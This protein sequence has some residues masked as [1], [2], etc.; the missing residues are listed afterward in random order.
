MFMNKVKLGNDYM[1]ALNGNNYINI[2][3]VKNGQIYTR[4]A[5]I[6]GN[7]SGIGRQYCVYQY[8]IEEDDF[9]DGNVYVSGSISIPENIV[10]DNVGNDNLPQSVTLR[11]QGSFWDN[12]YNVD[13]NKI[14]IDTIAPEIAGY[15]RDGTVYKE[16]ELTQWS[17]VFSEPISKGNVTVRYYDSPNITTI[18]N[19]ITTNAGNYQTNR[20]FNHT[21]RNGENNYRELYFS[22]Y[23]DKAGNE[24]KN[25]KNWRAPA[26]YENN[27]CADTTPPELI[28][29]HTM[30][31]NIVNYDFTLTDN[32]SRWL[33]TNGQLMN[34]AGVASNSLTI[35]DITLAN[36][37][38]ISHSEDNNGNLAS[39]QVLSNGDG[40]QILYI[41]EGLWSDAVGNKAVASQY[42]V[43]IDTKAPHIYNI[44]KSPCNWTN[45]DVKLTVFAEDDGTKIAGYSFD[46]GRS[47][48]E[49]NIYT[50]QENKK[51]KVQVKDERGKIATQTIEVDNIDKISPILELNKQENR[52]E[53]AKIIISGSDTES[54]IAGC[55]IN[56]TDV[57]LVNGSYE[58]TTTQNGTYTV[59]VYDQASNSTTK[60]IDITNINTSGI[61]NATIMYLVNGGNYILNRDSKAKLTEKV[62][63]TNVSVSKIEY[64]WSDSEQEPQ[65]WQ[66]NGF[67]MEFRTDKDVSKVGNYYLHVKVTDTNG[68]IT[69]S[70]SNAFQVEEFPIIIDDSVVTKEIEGTNYIILPKETESK[71]LLEKVTSISDKYVMQIRDEGCNKNITGKIRTGD[72][73]YL[74]GQEQNHKL[75]KICVLGDINKDGLINIMDIFQANQYRLEKIDFDIEQLIATDVNR[76]NNM[77]IND[78]FLI[79]QYRLEIIK[80]F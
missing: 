17:I 53:S 56:G 6:E 57:T 66:N 20:V 65:T 18:A 76:D 46:D 43:I 12:N 69:K 15:S 73:L 23:T 42:E 55:S 47:W 21:I 14:Y 61:P 80:S 45:G 72:I 22:N 30:N 64:A 39:L 60:T 35:S 37:T 71:D 63:V 19:E 62:V 1:T 34:K 75:Y 11:R 40:K 25:S 67:N 4:K 50:I 8:V 68:K 74:E 77:N 48:Q 26:G 54:G 41:K 27:Q 58:F 3:F 28:I 9:F 59:T 49:G 78:I 10:Y 51:I 52:T 29:S 32:S 44:D 38:I 7:N 2:G 79:N 70:H 13:N 5:I 36:G 24:L 31:E 16:G 33:T